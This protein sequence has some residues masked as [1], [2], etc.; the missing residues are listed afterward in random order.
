MRP[1][2]SR[3]LTL[4]SIIAIVASAACALMAPGVAS[5]MSGVAAHRH[6]M[7]MLEHGPALL[8]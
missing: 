3:Q 4:A 6:L 7:A 2:M 1:P 5:G 8:R